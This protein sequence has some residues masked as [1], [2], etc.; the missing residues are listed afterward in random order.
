MKQFKNVKRWFASVPMLCVAAFMMPQS[1]FAE[2]EAIDGVYQLGSAQD[3]V[4]FA[5]LVNGGETAANAVLTTDINMD[6][7]EFTP[8]GNVNAKYNGKFDGQN[9]VISNLVIDLLNILKI[10]KYT[11]LNPQL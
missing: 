2:I 4:E 5:T 10:Q 8:I 3:L 9:H 7:V 11:H 1:A 6:G